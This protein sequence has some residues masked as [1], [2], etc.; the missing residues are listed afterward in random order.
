MY[1]NFFILNAKKKDKEISIKFDSLSKALKNYDRLINRMQYERA[2]LF[3]V[4]D[5]YKLGDYTIK[6]TD[7][8]YY[9]FD[10]K[11]QSI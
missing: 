9:T 7:R 10:G 4:N 11:Y 2:D 6:S 5:Y 3:L 8:I 1:G